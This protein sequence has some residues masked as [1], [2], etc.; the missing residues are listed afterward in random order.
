MY[1]DNVHLL[2]NVWLLQWK[3]PQDVQLHTLERSYLVFL[4]TSAR[5]TSTDRSD[6]PELSHVLSSAH[7]AATNSIARA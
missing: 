1:R 7:R 4:L 2:S 3:I 6:F 5:P